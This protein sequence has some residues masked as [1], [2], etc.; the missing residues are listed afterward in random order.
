VAWLL[1]LPR[2]KSLAARSWLRVGR[3]ISLDEAEPENDVIIL[4]RGASDAGPEVRN[5][6]GHVGFFSGLEGDVIHVLGGNQGNSVS[7]APYNSARL[8]GARRL[9]S[10]S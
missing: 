7:V 10:C 3:V 4:R 1:R 5:A 6:P 8:L 9:I 2:S